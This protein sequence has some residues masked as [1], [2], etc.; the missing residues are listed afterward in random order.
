[1]SLAYCISNP[2]VIT[3]D[4]L[5]IFLLQGEAPLYTLFIVAPPIRHRDDLARTEDDEDEQHR[6]VETCVKSGSDKVVVALPGL[7]STSVEP[8][9]A[10][11]ADNE[12][13]DIS[14]REVAV[15]LGNAST[16]DGDI[17]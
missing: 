5:A 13:R 7:K 6:N 11:V 17:P 4:S 14:G 12:A 16:K 9:H 8:E 1:M 3:E 2:C 10:D 15:E